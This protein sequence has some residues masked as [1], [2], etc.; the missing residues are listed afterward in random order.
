MMSFFVSDWIFEITIG[1]IVFGFSMM[2]SEKIIS[3]LSQKSLGQKDI[4]IDLLDKMFVDVQPKQVTY[5]ML[6]F[7]YGFGSLVFLL[8]WPNILAGVLVGCVFVIG[9]WMLPKILIQGVYERRCNRFVDQMVDGMTIMANGIKSGLS[10]PQSMERVVENLPNPLSQ[11]FNLVL[12]QI[13][14]GRSVEEALIEMGERIPRAD[15]Q[16]FV[17]SINILKE[18]GGNMAETFTTITTTIRERQ[19]IEKKI[20]ALTAQGIMQ[21]VIVSLVPF[22][23]LIIF[24]FID[25]NFVMPLFT[26]PL[27]WF[28]LFIML[29]L[30]VIG[31]VMIRKIVKIDV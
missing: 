27:G 30:Q 12:S 20:E 13:R 16:M 29:G 3:W 17:T 8:F 11:E 23:L 14:I 7:S 5:A 6:S 21:G 22:G 19:K 31:G 25:P 4:I 9:G 10:V 2:H 28:F 18:T 26:R 24:L 15:V 1:L